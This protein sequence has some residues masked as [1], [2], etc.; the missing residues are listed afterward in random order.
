MRSINP[1]K[2]LQPSDLVHGYIYIISLPVHGVMDKWMLSNVEKVAH[3]GFDHSFL[4]CVS[5][6][7]CSSSSTSR[8]DANYCL[9][10]AWAGNILYFIQ[11][12]L[13]LEQVSPIIVFEL[14]F[15]K[16]PLILKNLNLK[17]KRRKKNDRFCNKIYKISPLVRCLNSDGCSSLTSQAIATMNVNRRFLVFF[18]NLLSRSLNHRTK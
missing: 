2:R 11:L 18:L 6:F 13:S 5:C 4:D 10:R 3:W 12:F 8:L 16:Y 9:W 1:K 7:S 17:K 14:H 15:F